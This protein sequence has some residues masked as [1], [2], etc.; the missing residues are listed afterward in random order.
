MR[1]IHDNPYKYACVCNVPY[2]LAKIACLK[3]RHYQKERRKHGPFCPKCGSKNIFYEMGSYEEGYGDY[4]ECENC[5]E[6]YE[7]YEIK[8]VDYIIPFRDFDTVLYFSSSRIPEEGWREACGAETIEEWQ[9]F[10]RE[11]ILRR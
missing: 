7:P 10:A 1:D 5:G 11:E 4:V 6:T 3:D 2:E 8:N 9:E